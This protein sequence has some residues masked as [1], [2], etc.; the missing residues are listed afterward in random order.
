MQGK[1]ERGKGKTGSFFF[2]PFTFHLS[3]RDSAVLKKAHR[4]T[5]EL[6]KVVLLLCIVSPTSTAQQ[7]SA[8]QPTTI[9]IPIATPRKFQKTNFQ[10]QTTPKNELE[11]PLPAMKKIDI[12]APGSTTPRKVKKDRPILTIR[13]VLASVERSYPLLVAAFQERGITDGRFLSSQGAFDFNFEGFDYVKRDSFDSHR[14]LLGFNQGLAF[15][16]IDVSAGYR[17]GAGEYPAYYGD[18]QTAQGGAFY[19]I[20][21]MP[22]LQNRTID[23]RR[24]TRTKALIGRQLA[25]PNIV[26]KRLDFVRQASLAYWNWVA[27]RQRLLVAEEFLE[28]AEKRDKL[29]TRKFELKRIGKIEVI[30]NRRLVTARRMRLVAFQRGFERASIDLSLFLR[31]EGGQ[32][33]RPDVFWRPPPFPNPLL[34]DVTKIPADVELALR[35]R[36]ELQAFALRREKLEVELGFF[37][38]QQLPQLNLYLRSEIDVGVEKKSLDR[39]EQEA[40]ILLNVPLQRRWAR[41]KVLTTQSQLAQINALERFQR[42]KISAEVQN[43]VSALVRAY[44]E[45]V[46]A[47]ETVILTKQVEDAEV[48]KFNAGKSTILIVNLRELATADAKLQAVDA[49]VKYYLA[50]ADYYTVLGLGSRPI[51]GTPPVPNRPMPRSPTA[52]RTYLPLPRNAR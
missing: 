19:G 2:P 23:N 4:S 36:P 38:N 31:N 11:Q 25:E 45:Q 14:F 21:R 50:L 41:G 33:V 44:E 37:N 13:Q 49:L 43:A 52:R 5:L 46:Q 30:D 51:L 8:P 15:Q 32:P 17:M 28:I 26:V 3:G 20:L 16:G 6:A 24:A 29:L 35:T 39:N 27:A 47:K 1:G 42:E 12:P 7:Y 40:G 48:T 18:R 9:G 10:E 34:P 22:L